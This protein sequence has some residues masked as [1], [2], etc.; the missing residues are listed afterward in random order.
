MNFVTKLIIASSATVGLIYL[1]DYLYKDSQKVDSVI[2]ENEDNNNTSNLDIELSKAKRISKSVETQLRL[3]LNRNKDNI[4][5]TNCKGLL[6]DYNDDTNVFSKT[7]FQTEI[8]GDKECIIHYNFCSFNWNEQNKITLMILTNN[9][10]K[11]HLKIG[12]NGE[13]LAPL[14][15]YKGANVINGDKKLEHQFIEDY[16]LL[17]LKDILSY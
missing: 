1:G 8:E 7:V 3:I 15:V 13:K 4:S 17:P 10:I 6:Y 11:D 5:N 14:F 16:G 9:I 12:D 2:L